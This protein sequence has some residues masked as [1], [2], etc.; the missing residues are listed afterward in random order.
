MTKQPTFTER[1]PHEAGFAEI[2]DREIAP[3][4]GEVEEQRLGLRKQRMKRIMITAA[5]VAAMVVMGIILSFALG[6][7][8]SGLLLALPVAGLG[9]WWTT[10]PVKRYRE[11]L[12]E[13]IIGPTVGFFENLEYSRDP[14]DRFDYKRFTKLGLAGGFGASV[15][16][17]DL[18]VG[19]HRGTEFKMIEAVFERRRKEYTETLFNGLLFEIAAPIEFSGRVIIGRDTGDVGNA[20]KGFFKRTF[21][22]QERVT[23][24][25]AAFEERYA[26]YSDSPDEAYRLV[27]PGFCKTMVDLADAYEEDSLSAAFV[28]NVFLLAL[29]IPGDLFELGS[30]KRPATECEKD[31][32]EF[33]QSITIAHRVIDYLHGDRP[34]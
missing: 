15:S 9:Y 29:P 19:R 22:K 18:F 26:V 17:E 27:T 20:L 4:L 12:R 3:R 34:A 24:D 2:F 6:G 32:H 28:D 30:I 5:A 8:L 31:I 16:V 14:G 13:V 1:E 10:F 7:N 11:S 25:D 33:M 21:G 23:F